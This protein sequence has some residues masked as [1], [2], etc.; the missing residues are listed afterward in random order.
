[1]A[2]APTKDYEERNEMSNNMSSR[3]LTLGGWA[4]AML[5]LTCGIALALALFA[6]PARA[7]TFNVSNTNNSGTGSLREAISSANANNARDTITFSVTGTITLTGSDLT[8][9]DD[10][11]G[12]DLTIDGPGANSLAVNGGGNDRVFFINSGAN[13]TI[14]G[15]AVTGGS[16]TDFGG[17]IRNA[18]TLTVNNATVSDNSA[19]GSGGGIYN[20]GTLTINS[21]TVSGNSADFAGGIFSGTSSVSA[22]TPNPA[23]RTTIRNSTISGNEASSRG[24]GVRNNNGLTIIENSTITK[25]TAPVDQGAGV[26]SVGGTFARTDVRATIISNNAATDVDHSLSFGTST[27]S[28]KSLGSNVVG[29]GNAAGEFNKTKDQSGV[30]DPKLGAL[31]NNGGTTKTHKL[32]SGSPAVDAATTVTFPPLGGSPCGVK[33]DQ[34]GVSRP[35]DGDNNVSRVCDVGSFELKA[36]PPVNAPIDTTPP[37]TDI[38]S[39]P[40]GTVRSTTAN[41]SFSSNEAG[42]TF[43][44][45]LDL[46]A[47]TAC[48]SPKKYTGLANRKHTFRV[49]AVDAA[50]NIDATPAVRNWRVDRVKPAISKISPKRLTKDRTPRIKA[51]V[52][53]NVT[54]LSKSNIVLKVNGKNVAKS[55]FRYSRA[56][57]KLVYT[58]RPKLPRGKRVAV[59]IVARDAAGNVGNKSW[60][61]RIRR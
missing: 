16:N 7:G 8:V 59:K 26:S 19:T 44:C 13:A 31:A 36:K 48:S 25:N 28:F 51:T 54:N 23:E 40:S 47:F 39:G 10:V 45:S 35:Q 27:N 58:V 53:D 15:L 3:R 34:R 49:K 14:E 9:T 22:T 60:R 12:A 57:D 41:F 18:G 42:S 29:D 32:L 20:N 4:Q 1:M 43:Q 24:G 33:T 5:A 46:E 21:S 50:S 2:T 37:N 6:N 17:G 38:N 52:R 56:R 55:K 30:T 11:S 61:F